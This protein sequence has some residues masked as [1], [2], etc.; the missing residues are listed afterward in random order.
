MSAGHCFGV[1]VLHNAILFDQAVPEPLHS[2]EEF[3]ELVTAVPTAAQ[4]GRYA[5]A[6]ELGVFAQIF[7]SHLILLELL[8]AFKFTEAQPKF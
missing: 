1:S 3:I 5:S 6:V 4:L 8:H 7:V 2:Q